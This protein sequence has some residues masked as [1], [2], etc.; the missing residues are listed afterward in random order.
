MAPIRARLDYSHDGRVATIAL[1]APKANI[2]DRAMI[3]AI[4]AHLEAVAARDDVAVL[5]IAADGPHFSFGASVEEHL[6]DQIGATLTSLHRLLRRMIALPAPTVAAVRGMCLGG[7][8]EL[9]L[10]CDLIVAAEGAQFACPEIK[11]GVFPPA[12]SALLPARIGSARAAAMTLT[13]AALTARQAETAGLVARVVADTD[14]DVAPAAFVA[15]T[16]ASRSAVALRH[17]AAAIRQDVVRAIDAALPE[18]ER[19]YL[20]ELMTHPDPVEGIRAFLEKRP[21]RWAH[22]QRAEETR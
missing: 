4:E 19:L 22:A 5:V 21:P 10:A 11:L 8:F 9:V 3:A 18:A 13:G 2:V 1:A 20:D 7:G 15:E 14:F 12:A 16:F 6:P 17:A